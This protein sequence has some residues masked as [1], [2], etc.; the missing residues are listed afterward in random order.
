MFIENVDKYKVVET[1]QNKFTLNSDFQRG[2]IHE[3][4]LKSLLG[5]IGNFI[6]FFV[7]Y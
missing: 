5:K 1:F 4:A 3:L 7:S 2:G 6:L